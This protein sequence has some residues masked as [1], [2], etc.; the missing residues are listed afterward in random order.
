MPET[1]VGTTE[2]AHDETTDSNETI[3]DAGR[4]SVRVRWQ[5]LSV[6]ARLLQPLHRSR[7]ALLN[8]CIIHHHDYDRNPGQTRYARTG[9][10]RQWAAVFLHGICTIYLQIPGDSS[11]RH[12]IPDTHGRMDWQRKPCKSRADCKE[13]HN[14]GNGT[15][16]RSL[17]R[18]IG[19][20]Y[21][22]YFGLRK[23]TCTAVDEQ[24]FEIHST[25]DNGLAITGPCESRGYSTALRRGARETEDVLRQKRQNSCRYLSRRLDTAEEEHGRLPECG[26]HRESRHTTVVQCSYE[27][28]C[29]LQTHHAVDISRNR[30]TMLVR[31]LARLH[32]KH[33]GVSSW[34]N[35]NYRWLDVRQYQ[36][37]RN[38]INPQKYLW[39]MSCSAIRG[40]RSPV[41]VE[42]WTDIYK[43]PIRYEAWTLLYLWYFVM[44][45]FHCS[46]IDTWTM[47]FN[48]TTFIFVIFCSPP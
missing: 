36:L 17:H 44:L 24:T 41:A 20:P 47:L 10:L 23:V 16:S 6:T 29:N 1:Q 25:F 22:A 12:P 39:R 37:C 48:E 5:E 11:T 8:P 30:D 43:P 3:P 2:G 42:I 7:E 21:D 32:L 33:C 28:W 46:R 34:V 14:E 38:R 31:C 15:R 45:C 26:R 9:V 35:R 18:Y 19:V 4:R 40:E 13:N 27:G